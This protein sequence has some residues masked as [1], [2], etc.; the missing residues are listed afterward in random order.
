[1]KL[2]TALPLTLSAIA[3]L[4]TPVAG[5]QTPQPIRPG[6]GG[7]QVQPPRPSRPEVQPPRPGRPEIQPPRPGRPEIQP[8]RPPRPQPPRPPRPQPPRPPIVVNPG[9]A[10]A[11]LYSGR[12]WRGTSVTIR[13]AAPD[14]RLYRFNDR[15]ISLRATGRW[16]VCSEI[17][18]R[19]RCVIVRGSDANLGRIAGSVSSIRYLGR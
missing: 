3:M 14:L 16:Q 9:L 12:Q 8:P 5:A 15:A 1:M 11:V 7:P 4:L 10:V 17:W 19:G 13:R 2:A 6:Q 18:Y